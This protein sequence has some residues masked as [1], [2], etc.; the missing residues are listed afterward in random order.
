MKSLVTVRHCHE[1][2][3]AEVRSKLEKAISDC[4]IDGPIVRSGDR[5]LLKP[6]LLRSASPERAIV[7]HPA[8]VGAAAEILS[9]CGARLSI[10]DSPPLGNIQRVL[11]KSGYETILKRH[12]IETVPFVQKRTVEFGDDR[13]YRRLE[14]AAEV[15]EFDRVINIAKL[16]THC[17]MTLTLG[18]KNLFGLVIGSDKASWHLRAGRVTDNFAHVLLQIYE[19]ILPDISILDGILGMQGNGP[20]SGEP[21][22]VGILSASRDAIAMDA[23]VARLLGF[24]IDSVRTC[25]L[26][27]ELGLGNISSE[28]I[29]IAGDSL[30]AFPLTDFKAPKSM[31]MAWNLSYWNPIR[32]FMENHIIT[33]PEIDW[34]ACKNCG[35]CMNHCPPQA[36]SERNGKMVIDRRRCI[37]C[38]CCHE[39]C[40]SDAISIRQPFAGRMLSRLSR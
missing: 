25:I 16:K 5:V 9:D 33:K 18:V 11:A 30:T 40:G 20:N 32:R 27:K 14:L 1:Y 13:I 3:A 39:L 28:D 22:Y 26:G 7:T 34:D 17:Q 31:S 8:V 19:T 23:V 6:N 15:F 4:S 2:Q 24:P 37:S 36:I 38:F 10:G 29:E 35:I 21:R 12:D